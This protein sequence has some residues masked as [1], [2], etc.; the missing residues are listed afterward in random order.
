MPD[1]YR[2]TGPDSKCPACGWRI[3]PDA[4]R[5]PKCLIYFCYKCR[6]RV[7]KGDDQFQCVNQTCACHGKL[8][9]SA[10]TV[11]VPEFGDVTRSVPHPG[12][13]G[14][15][16]VVLW[17]A[18]IIGALVGYFTSST[19]GF[20]VAVAI[21]VVFAIY[22][23]KTGDHLTDQPTTYTNETTHERIRE[24]RCCIQCRTPTEILR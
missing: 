10:C 21:A 22:L 20:W 18:G 14:S 11:M 16:Q 19:V 15:G 24:H 5:C 2:R 3:D 4:Y 9:C 13:P 6:K 8:L 17:T 12:K 23:K 7:Q 1:T